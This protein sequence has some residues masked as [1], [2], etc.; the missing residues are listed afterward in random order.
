MLKSK[1][2]KEKLLQTQL[3]SKIIEICNNNYQLYLPCFRLMIKSLTYSYTN[4][5]VFQPHYSAY[6]FFEQVRPYL[7]V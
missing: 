3:I 6:N 5:D 7:I 4:E 1:T 2:E